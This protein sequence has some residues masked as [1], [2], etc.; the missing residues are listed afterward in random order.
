M[1]NYT[2]I[3]WETERQALQAALVPEIYVL[4]TLLEKTK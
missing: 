3:Y 4:I 1:I 2:F